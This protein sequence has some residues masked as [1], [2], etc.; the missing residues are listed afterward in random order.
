MR[1]AVFALALGACA[2]PIELDPPPSQPPLAEP[3]NEDHQPADQPLKDCADLPYCLESLRTTAD[4]VRVGAPV[5]IEPILRNPEGHDLE[6]HVLEPTAR[7]ATGRP[8]LVWAEID[9]ALRVDADTG[10]ASFR[11]DAVPPWFVETI[12]TITVVAEGAHGAVAARVDLRLLGN[13][14]FSTGHWASI[15]AVGS[16]GRPATGVNGDHPS[17]LLAAR[18]LG[19]VCGVALRRDGTL[20]AYDEP[21]GEPPRLVS[22]TLDGVDRAPASLATLDRGGQPLLSSDNQACTSIVALP[23]GRVAAADVVT[24]RTP[25]SRVVIWTA[26]GELDRIVD[27]TDPAA[28]WTGLAA[29]NGSLFVVDRTNQTLASIEPGPAVRRHASFGEGRAL[30]AD[31]DGAFLM[32]GGR[33]LSRFGDAAPIEVT[34]A[35]VPAPSWRA[36]AAGPEGSAMAI[37]TDEAS[38]GN[39]YRIENDRVVGPVRPEQVGGVHTEIFGAAYLE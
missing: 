21:F 36:L 17:G 11:L 25:R 10:E 3:P 23:D 31:N 39:M 6:F 20:V 33:H 13:T 34:D 12:V 27:A 8:A 9:T 1:T 35:P 32:A 30:L 29:S 5:R 15:N 24:N 16:D 26:D 38:A 14:V 7:R 28:E 18:D 22:I 2:Q 19:D 4:H 37:T